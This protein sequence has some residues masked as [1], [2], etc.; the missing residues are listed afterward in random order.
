MNPIQFLQ[1]FLRFIADYATNAQIITREFILLRNMS[2]FSGMNT[3]K[4]CQQDATEL[5]C[6]VNFIIIQSNFL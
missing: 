2:T 3:F 4:F 6:K 5:T 1:W